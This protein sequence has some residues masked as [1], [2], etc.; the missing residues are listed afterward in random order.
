MNDPTSA[1]SD[2]KSFDDRTANEIV[3][4]ATLLLATLLGKCTPRR[5]E[6][7]L[8]GVTPPIQICFAGSGPIVPV[9]SLS[10]SKYNTHAVAHMYYLSMLEDQ[11]QFPAFWV[12]KNISVFSR[13][14]SGPDAIARDVHQAI[15]KIDFAGVIAAGSIERI[16]TEQPRHPIPWLIFHLAVCSAYLARDEEAQSLLQKSIDLAKNENPAAYANLI[17]E[18]QVDLSKLTSDPEGFRSDLIA[19]MASNWSHFKIVSS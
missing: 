7:L 12:D 16:L 1:N 2:P 8:F 13:L 6:Y 17:S 19:T 4:R 10:S 11:R 15:K 3:D 5:S 9:L 14:D 18:A